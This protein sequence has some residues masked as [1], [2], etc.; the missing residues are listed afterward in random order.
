[1]ISTGAVAYLIKN[2]TP[3]LMIETIKQVYETR[4]L[5]ILSSKGIINSEQHVSLKKQ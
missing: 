3:K 4:M 1:M 2:S 5:N